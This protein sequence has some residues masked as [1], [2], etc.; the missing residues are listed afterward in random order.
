MEEQ[1]Q[2]REA[3]AEFVR[4]W[5]GFV[6]ATWLMIFSGAYG[7]ANYSTQLKVVLGITQ[8]QL[9]SLSVAKDLGDALG[10]VAG[11]LSDRLPPSALLCIG[12]AIALLGYGAQYLV[13]SQTIAP[14][15]FWTVSYLVIGI[16]LR[17]NV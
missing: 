17:T 7:F 9:N 15:P 14:L 10:I 11:F 5:A 1:Q 6:A 13:I 4:R 16:T 3:R 2:Q 12:A 8:A